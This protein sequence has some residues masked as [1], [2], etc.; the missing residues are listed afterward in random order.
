MPKHISI[1]FFTG[2]LL[3]AYGV[4]I[5]GAGVYALSHPPETHV[6]LESLHIEIWWGAMLTVIGAVYCWKFAPSG[7]E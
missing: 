3:L 7:K 1:W 2:V 6:V 4:I 5:C